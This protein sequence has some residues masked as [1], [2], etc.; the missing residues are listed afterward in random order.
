TKDQWVLQRLGSIKKAAL[1]GAETVRRIHEFSR[2]ESD[3]AELV[4]VD[5]R[6]VV[7]DAVE[8]T[9]PRWKDEAEQRGGSIRMST[10][11]RPLAPVMGDPSE[12]REVMVNVI[13]NAIEAMPGGGDILVSCRMQDSHVLVT[14]TDNGG[15]VTDDVKERVFDPF[16]TTKGSE[17][18]G[19]GLSVSYGIVTR[20]KG[21]ITLEGEPGKGT[22]VEIRLPAADVRMDNDSVEE[23]RP[24]T[25]RARI[26][27][28]ENNEA[29][30]DTLTE[31]LRLDGHEVGAFASAREGI[32]AFD[33]ERYEAVFTDLGMP[34]MSGWEVARTI[35]GRDPGMP[36]VLVTGWASSVSKKEMKA[37]GVDIVLGKPFEREQ[38]KRVV[39]RAL[40]IRESGR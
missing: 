22:T 12:L 17:G 3:G 32:A 36:V 2:V 8:F 11:L 33:P 27:L 9:K 24:G 35:K 18:S 7:R 5:I 1:E 16:F 15:G 23:I 34:E 14:V 28:I 30:R 19:L 40:G 6:Q 20:H 26:L 25:K 13:F 39:A 38:M 10:D 37:S 31:M 21:E 29:L 4:P